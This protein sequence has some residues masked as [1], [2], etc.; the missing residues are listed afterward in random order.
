VSRLFGKRVEESNNRGDP[1]PIQ[2]QPPFRVVN[3][4]RQ[5]SFS[6]FGCRD[7]PSMLF[8]RVK[9]LGN[10]ISALV[11][12]GSIRTFLGSS[13]VELVNRLKLKF[14]KSDGRR[15]VMATGQ[16]TRVRGEVDLPFTLYDRTN[17]LERMPCHH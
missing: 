3:C 2:P 13:V 16:T 14:R 7:I 12:C 6:A 15:V 1:T 5:F 4:S 11:D 9:I 17:S 10:E 8:I